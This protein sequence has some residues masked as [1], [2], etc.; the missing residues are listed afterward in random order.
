[1]VVVVVVMDLTVC[2][3]VFVFLLGVSGAGPMDDAWRQV[4]CPPPQKRVERVGQKKPENH[5]PEVI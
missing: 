4:W 3:F 5:G 1:V 2:L